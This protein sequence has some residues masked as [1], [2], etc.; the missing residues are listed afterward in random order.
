MAT[1]VPNGVLVDDEAVCTARA[2]S[3]RI[4]S[5]EAECSSG[6][7]WGAPDMPTIIDEFVLTL[8]ESPRRGRKRERP[9]RFRPGLKSRPSPDCPGVG[10]PP[11]GRGGFPAPSGWAVRD[12][13]SESAAAVG[14]TPRESAA[15]TPA[16]PEA[17]V[18]VSWPPEIV[19]V[20]VTLPEFADNRFRPLYTELLMKVFNCASCAVK[21]PHRIACSL[22]VLAALQPDT[23]FPFI[24]P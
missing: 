17:L 8:G 12:E 16:K 9:G 2:M 7:I 5:C 1:S 23:P 20:M 3:E 11:R 24:C 14:P 18:S 21:L 22:P 19:E 13:R 10:R 15:D 4:A 6:A